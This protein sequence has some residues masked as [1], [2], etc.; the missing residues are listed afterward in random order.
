MAAMP[1]KSVAFSKG[2]AAV[3]AGGRRRFLFE[4]KILNLSRCCAGRAGGHMEGVRR[5]AVGIRFTGSRA[6]AETK[7]QPE[8]DTAN[9]TQNAHN[10]T[11]IYGNGK[12]ATHNKCQRKEL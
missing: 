7:V 3:R 4:N 10:A 1:T 2:F 11:A 9:N 5:S 6:P 12:E 8:A